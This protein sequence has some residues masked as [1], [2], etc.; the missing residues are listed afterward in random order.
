MCFSLFSLKKINMNQL[1]CMKHYACMQE[2][3]PRE[4]VSEEFAFNAMIC[5]ITLVCYI[6][7]FLLRE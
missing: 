1:N 4:I 2:E 5:G 3:S 6:S 7:S